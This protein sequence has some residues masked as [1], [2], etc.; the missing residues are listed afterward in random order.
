MVPVQRARHR[1]LG[2]VQVGV[3]VLDLRLCCFIA[4]IR[5]QDL[6]ARGERVFERRAGH[7]WTEE[8]LLTLSTAG[9]CDDETRRQ[10]Y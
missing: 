5:K 8:D 4:W 7:W 9:P 6:H 10:T 3:G 1:L 2:L